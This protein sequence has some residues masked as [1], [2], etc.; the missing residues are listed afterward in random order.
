MSLTPDWVL[1]HRSHAAE[2]SGGI[3]SEA[4]YQ[5][6]E[7]VITEKN[8]TGS[9]LDYGAGVGNLSRRLLAG[10]RFQHIAAADIRAVP[11]DLDGLI[12]WIEQDLNAPMAG[13][14]GWFDAVVAVEVIEHLENPRLMIREMWRLLNPGGTAIVTTPNNESWR[15]V[16]SLL[17]RGHFVAFSDSCYP[18][19]IT[20]LLRRDFTRIFQEAGFSAPEFYFTNDG[21]IPGNPSVSWQKVSLGRLRGLRF[22]DNIAAVAKKPGIHMADA[23]RE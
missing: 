21:G 12:E 11:G 5:C 17:A 9:V 19:H 2:R 18:A 20:A 10:K 7:R 16:A 3:S 23:Q 13:R 22:S 4:I 1:E 8:L 15:S 14:D 6:V